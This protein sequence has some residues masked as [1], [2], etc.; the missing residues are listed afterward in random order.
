MDKNKE[1][2]KLE[3]EKEALQ[4]KNQPSTRK[5]G[6]S[7]ERASKEWFYG[8]L[9]KMVEIVSQY[10]EVESGFWERLD[11]NKKGKEDVR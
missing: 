11:I 6:S 5:I 7:D 1:L 9:D 4:K 10:A 2:T 8:S 3:E